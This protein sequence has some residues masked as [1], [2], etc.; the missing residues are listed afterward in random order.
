MS[1]TEKQSDVDPRGTL[2]FVE[3]QVDGIPPFAIERTRREVAHRLA[4]YAQCLRTATVTLIDVNGPL[5]GG[6]DKHCLIV[7][8]LH[9]PGGLVVVEDA[10]GDIT[11]V[12]ERAALRTAAAVARA[13]SS[14][15]LKDQ[16]RSAA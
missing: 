8:A 4:P 3:V 16:P 13:V 5:L 15:T 14:W 11:A 1:C 2:D 6:N 7:V 12:V 9:A 10:G